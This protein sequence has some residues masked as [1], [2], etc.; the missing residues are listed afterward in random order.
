MKSAEENLAW[1]RKKMHI[2]SQNEVGVVTVNKEQKPITKLGSQRN[3]VTESTFTT[4]LIKRSDTG[5]QEPK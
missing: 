1:H 4:K 5:E 2:S 3:Q